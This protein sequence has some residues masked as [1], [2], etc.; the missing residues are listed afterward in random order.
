[1]LELPE[2]IEDVLVALLPE[3]TPLLAPAP[4]EEPP[5]VF[6]RSGAGA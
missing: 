2:D 3:E 5:A 6:S 4:V 1:M